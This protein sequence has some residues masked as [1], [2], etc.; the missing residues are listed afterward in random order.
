MIIVLTVVLYMLFHSHQTHHQVELARLFHGKFLPS[1]NLH[2][3]SEILFLSFQFRARGD[4]ISAQRPP[5]RHQLIIYIKWSWDCFKKKCMLTTAPLNEVW[6]PGMCMDFTGASTQGKRELVSSFR[7]P[8]PKQ[9]DLKLFLNCIIYQL[10]DRCIK[11]VAW[12]GNWNWWR[13]K[14]WTRITINRECTNAPQRGT[15]YRL[16]F[17]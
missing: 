8:P 11:T 12:Y 10:S 4:H 2:S 6:V 3:Y 14:I 7:L 5:Q 9:R 13:L 17:L 1:F 16:R 15:C